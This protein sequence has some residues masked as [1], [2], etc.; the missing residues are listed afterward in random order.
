MEQIITQEEYEKLNK[1]LNDLYMKDRPQV[2]A[3]LKEAIS[4]GDLSENA[5][6]TEAKDRQAEIE[7]RIKEIETKLTNSEIVD[8]DEG[9][10]DDIGIGSTFRVLDQESSAERTFSIVG[11]EVSDPLA[12]KISFDSPLGNAFLHKKVEEVVE[13]VTP[14]GKRAY[15]VLEIM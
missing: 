9:N 5:A 8:E 14:G 13:V 6:Y 15:K 1:E 12:G 4:Q 11:P 7:K 10:K 2:A 3:D